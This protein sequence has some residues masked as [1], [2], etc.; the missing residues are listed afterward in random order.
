M[1]IRYTPTYFT[2]A[3]SYNRSKIGMSSIK[4]SVLRYFEDFEK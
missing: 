3:T 1:Y 4:Q 2:T